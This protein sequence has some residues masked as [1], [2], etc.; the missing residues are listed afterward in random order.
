MPRDLPQFGASSK[1]SFPVR[2]SSGVSDVLHAGH[3]T[4]GRVRDIQTKIYNF[5]QL[6]F[7]FGG[8]QRSL[9]KQALTPASRFDTFFLRAN[10]FSLTELSEFDWKGEIVDKSAHGTEFNRAKL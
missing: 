10:M 3:N 2:I 8:G 4:R 1:I 6:L 5:G 7:L 9:N